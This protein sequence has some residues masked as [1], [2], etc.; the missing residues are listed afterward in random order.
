[1]D[2]HILIPID[3]LDSQEM[4]LLG[5]ATERL[6]Q[7]WAA[8]PP[9]PRLA[10]FMPPAS[11]RAW[12]RLMVELVKEDIDCRREAAWPPLPVDQ[13]LTQCRLGDVA[14]ARE[15]LAAAVE[16]HGDTSL[17][18]FSGLGVTADWSS[19]GGEPAAPLKE[20]DRVGHYRVIRSLGHGG[21]GWVYLAED[22]ELQKQVAVKIPHRDLFRSDEELLRFLDEARNE[23][24]LKHP[25]IVPIHYFG[26]EPDGACYIVMEYIDGPCLA[27]PIAAGPLPPRE[28]AD[29][30]A[31]VAGAV[32]HIHKKGFVHRDLKSRNILLDAEGRPHVA[33]FG[34]ALHESAQ[35]GFAGDSS[36][37]LAYMPPEQVEGKADWLDG[38]ADLWA[39]GVIFYEMLTGRRPFQGG[40]Y[41]KVKQEILHREPKPPRAINDQVPAELERICLKCLA[42]PVGDRYR[43]ADDLIADLHRWQQP[44]RRPALALL[45]IGLTAVVL[46]CLT[47]VWSH[48]PSPVLGRGAGGE[49]VLP[50]LSGTVDL[51]VWNKAD[52]SR[53]GLSLREPRIMPLR[54]LDKIRVEAKLNRPAYVYLIWIDSQGQASPIYPWEPGEWKGLPARQSPTDHLSLPEAADE[55]WPI[56]GP[57]GMETLLLLARN[58]PLPPDVDLAGLLAGFP[59]QPMLD[60]RMLAWFDNGRV[61]TTEMDHVRGLGL[62]EQG[63]IDDAVLKTQQL[64]KERLT[65][66]FSLIR[67]VT[68]AS[69]GG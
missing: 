21:M 37:T 18:S 53:R 65:P 68:V 69:K 2:E 26:R 1:M 48:L 9:E 46:A 36:G 22:E 61:V 63:Q 8:A 42:K 45:A 15:E 10:D 40:S 64:I 55:G 13:Y 25:G 32:A 14:G 30:L 23:A 31:T 50:Q 49:G 16:N 52:P 41:E 58:E 60:E 34:L 20:S 39:L 56:Q 5:R 17:K 67:T 62:K 6:Q 12:P 27:E 54:P 44:R 43:T 11:D 57:G 35:H 51:L 59:R 47:I 7:A 29:I 4:E 19:G 33:D 66:Y 24:K 3:A 38:R 28:A